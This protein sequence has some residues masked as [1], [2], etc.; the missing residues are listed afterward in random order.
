MHIIALIFTLVLA[1]SFVLFSN[2]QLLLAHTFS[3]NENALFLTLIDKIKAEIQLVELDSSN[4]IQQAQAHANEAAS[5]LTQNDQVVNTTWTKEISERNPRVEIDLVNSLI[6]LKNSASSSSSSVSPNSVQSKV[7]NIGNI[8]DEAVSVRIDKA[9]LN[10]SRTQALVIANLG[11]EIYNNYGN[12]LGLPPTTIASMGG[13]NMSGMSMNNT[14]A[15]SNI[16]GISGMS[17]A[18]KG[19]SGMSS[20]SAQTAMNQSNPAIKNMTAYETAQS[21]ASMAQQAFSK[22]LKPI[23]PANATSYTASIEKYIGQ[24]KNAIDTKASFMNVV[25]L[26]HV[27][28]HPTLITAYNLT[29]G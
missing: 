28:L 17:M 24:L 29:T 6:D 18:S 16:G 23:V 8:L 13:M 4:N 10:N 12:A 26:V 20:M 1:A 15:K 19:M 27:R 5:L 25:E 3:E 14:P 7:A 9:L 2:P 11:N 21:L 22:N